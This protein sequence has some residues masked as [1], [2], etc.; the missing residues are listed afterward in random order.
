CP[1]IANVQDLYPPTA[2]ELGLMGR[3]PMLRLAERLELLLYRKAAALIVHSPGACDY[4]IAKGAP[5]ERVH[6][7]YNWA[8]LE[9]GAGADAEGWR[10]RHG[11]GGAFLVTF[12]GTMGFA[13]DLQT[14]VE[15]AALT[16]SDSSVVWALAGDGVMRGEVERAVRERNLANVRLLPPQAPDDYYAMLRASDAGLVTL[17]PLLTAPVTPGKAQALMAAGVP[18]VCAAH[19]ATDLKRLVEESGAGVFVEAGDAQGL[20]DAAL[21]LRA[22]PE[23]ARRMAEAG[24][25]FAAAH[26]DRRSATDAYAALLRVPARE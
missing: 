17:S 24:R 12:A 19:P 7:V 26:F 1:L 16:T 20:A 2:V 25:A 23:R 5:P 15:A 3:G 4:L 13:Q 22:D 6:V 18:I 8:D 10:A 21:A 9:A 14:V 11:L